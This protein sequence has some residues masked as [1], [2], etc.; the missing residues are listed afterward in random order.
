[1]YQNICRSSIYN[2]PQIETTQMPINSS[3]VCCI[4][5]LEYYTAVNMNEF[6]PLHIKI[7]ITL[8]KIMLSERIQLQKSPWH[9]ILFIHS[10]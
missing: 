7:R 3:E 10:G 2:L 5:T 4:R 8:T 6:F 1:M 9:I